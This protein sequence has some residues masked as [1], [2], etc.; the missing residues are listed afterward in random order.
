M[1]S[2]LGSKTRGKRDGREAIEFKT[3]S[4][5]KALSAAEEEA[6]SDIEGRQIWHPFHSVVHFREVPPCV[7]IIQNTDLVRTLVYGESPD[8]HLDCFRR[9]T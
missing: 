8:L 2:L 1:R 6:E 5:Y 4:V 3:G 7:S 9:G